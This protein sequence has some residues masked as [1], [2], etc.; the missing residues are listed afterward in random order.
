MHLCFCINHVN[1][2]VFSNEFNV[3]SDFV[4]NIHCLSDGILNKTYYRRDEKF[5]SYLYSIAFVQYLLQFWYFIICNVVPVLLDR[6]HVFYYDQWFVWM[7]RKL[8]FVAQ[9]SYMYLRREITLKMFFNW[10]FFSRNTLCVSV[11][12]GFKSGYFKNCV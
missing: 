10:H 6:S 5:V 9:L 11:Y 7:A 12:V 1:C 3:V 4:R 8:L 2:F